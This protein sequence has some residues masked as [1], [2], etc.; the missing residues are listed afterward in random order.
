[1]TRVIRA[2]L[3]EADP[4]DSER[5]LAELHTASLDVKPFRVQTAE[6][7]REQL[8]S[9][10][11]DV[12]L[13]NYG[14][15]D[16][17]GASALA[18]AR[19]LAP[20]VP[21]LFVADSI[22]EE[23]AVEA[24]KAGAADWVLK[25]RLS[26]LGP[27][28]HRALDRRIQGKRRRADQDQ[29]RLI[30][31]RFEC[32]AKA[33]SDAVWEWDIAGDEALAHATLEK[34]LG[35]EHDVRWWLSRLHPDDRERLGTDLRAAV[36]RR[37]HRWNA[38]YRFRLRDD[39]YVVV[40]SRAFIVS[41]PRG[42]PLRVIGALQ[43]LTEQRRADQDFRDSALRDRLVTESAGDGIVLTT[44]ASRIVYANLRAGAM[45]GVAPDTLV[46]RSFLDLLPKSS[47]DQHQATLRDLLRDESGVAIHSMMA[48]RSDGSEFPIELSVALGKREGDLYFTKI[49]RDISER[50]AD[51][52]R[53]QTQLRVTWLLASSPSPEQSLPELVRT[54][55]TGLGWEGAAIW[56]LDP[57]SRRLN[58]V[59]FL[60]P[61]GSDREVVTNATERLS[62]AEGEGL[63][64]LAF[65][66]GYAE[67]VIIADDEA[68][69]HYAA[70]LV[71]GTLRATAVPIRIE[72]QC[73]GVLEFFERDGRQPQPA[74]LL[75]TEEIA[76]LIAHHLDRVRREEERRLMTERLREAQHLAHLGSWDFDIRTGVA[77]CSEETYAILGFELTDDLGFAESMNAVLPDDRRRVEAALLS[78]FETGEPETL[79]V[80]YRV[81]RKGSEVVVDCCSRVFLDD[82]GVPI[83]AA[84][85]LQDV[86]EQALANRTIEQ[87]MKRTDLILECAAEGII[88]VDR[89]GRTIFSNPAACALFGWTEAGLLDCPDTHS[90]LHHT[91]PDGTPFP[92]SEC[93]LN[94]TLQDG[95]KRSISNEFF[96]RR[97]GQPFAVSYECAAIVEGGEIVGGVLTFRDV[98]ESRRLNRQLDLAKRIGSLGR[99]AAT[100]AHEFNNV[101]MGIEP[102]A[103]IIRRRAKDDEKIV[104][105]A[106]QISSSVRRGRRVT[107]EILR[108]TRPVD[109]VFKDVDLRA[110]LKLLEPE[111]QV[112]AGP[113]VAIELTMP[114]G[115]V[116][117]ACDAAQLQQVIT[118]LVL[119]AR[120]AMPEGGKIAIILRIGAL[121]VE[122][123]VRDG[124][125]GISTSD[126][127][128]V[129]EP[130][131]TTKRGGTGLGLAVAR[132]VV[133]RH[134]GT[135]EVSNLEGGGAEFRITLPFLF[136]ATETPEE[137]ATVP[138]TVGGEQRRL[139]L[140]EDEQAIALG[141]SSL[142]ESEGFLVRWIA[143]GEGV[144]D[145]VEAFH[146]DA[147]IL[148][149]TLP[150]I[151]GD[152]VF[153]RLRERW[154]LLPV[155]FSTGHG[156]EGDLVEQL[157]QRHVGLLQKPYAIEALVAAVDRVVAT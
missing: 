82:H 95:Q 78:Q 19:E 4:R 24:L 127:E 32:A 100:I 63:I 28:I 16:V 105:A 17:D 106:D 45:F 86:T 110:W 90:A 124:G 42:V 14:V 89:E 40:S 55:V 122:L 64:G 57:N 117:A 54:M 97:D 85:T 83:R 8:V 22:G 72:S 23:K 21:F 136:S 60:V 18:M 109:P 30:S 56:L 133:T 147:V 98:T 99:V 148:D 139:L 96:Y 94:L 11:I 58:C 35:E 93:A 111:L 153:D 48:L 130:L 81:E 154:P 128:T 52:H 142:L 44:T 67:T 141:L 27:A 126:L 33:T 71:G 9:S 112:L 65:R 46:G 151:D 115:P 70:S 88:G 25:D 121:A 34:P 104:K 132:Q 15:S 125:G 123:I 12:I 49:I 5:I 157:G 74:T 41:D 140:V 13:A 51:E 101:L 156:G 75:V 73:F 135:I 38:E 62:V 113:N 66:S 84:G 31:Q 103:E 118:N 92:R 77:S 108:F 129:F 1:M 43:D 79:R 3:L 107:D 29:L 80:R 144:N 69:P 155:V 26:R 120:D 91:K 10:D 39:A 114:A 2:L 20:E 134:L 119:N 6:G 53:R 138:A 59:A 131:F 146:P 137:G 61:R 87:L 102:F 37:D 68:E 143:S 116:M 36:A 149:L 145:A 50:S 76:G 152:V 7:F 47:S 150:D